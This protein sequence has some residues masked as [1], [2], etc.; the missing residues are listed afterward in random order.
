MKRIIGISG[1]IG[2]GKTTLCKFL[3]DYAAQVGVNA[4][5][6]SFADPIKHTVASVF[7]VNIVDCYTQ[8]GKNKKIEGFDITVGQALQIVGA[9]LRDAIDKD[10]WVK[11]AMKAINYQ[12]S[13]NIV[14]ISDVRFPNEVEAIR[15]AGGF[16]VRLVGDPMGV[17][18]NSNRDLTHESET[19]LDNYQWTLGSVIDNSKE[20]MMS[21]ALTAEKIIKT[22]LEGTAF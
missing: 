8:E 2:S 12:A 16:V 9:T 15:K 18:A 21:L 13:T 17:R 6:V 11:A 7:G 5:E 1:K 20:D 4:E 22:A 19:A 3:K 14:I 10:I